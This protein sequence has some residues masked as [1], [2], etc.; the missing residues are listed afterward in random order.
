MRLLWIG[1]AAGLFLGTSAWA[2]DARKK[3]DPPAK[4]QQ[5]E[6][7]TPKDKFV[8][9]RKAMTD[10]QAEVNKIVGELRKKGEEVSLNNKELRAAFEAS[11]KTR[12][13]AV[14]AANELAKADPKSADGFEAL[15]YVINFGRGTPEAV[16]DVVQS[17]TEH[18]VENPKIGTL[19]VRIPVY[20]PALRKSAETFFRAVIE[21]NPSREAKGQATMALAQA[22]LSSKPKEAEKLFEKVVAEYG[23]VKSFRGTLAKAAEANLFELRHL[24][25]GMVAPDIE[26]EDMEGK[27]FKLSDYRG[28][29]VM[30]DFWGHW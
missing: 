10:S 8:A 29:V 23:D 19:L 16:Q 26:G 9:A 4:G 3:D 14:E 7:K 11:N 12:E 6:P 27:K 18:H 22:L 17:L 5:G 21:K 15:S 24:Q 20:T 2:D 28:K 25:V 1:T 30:L 13:A